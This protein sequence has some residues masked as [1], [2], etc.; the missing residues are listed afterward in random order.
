V[1]VMGIS[2]I[3]RDGVT[4]NR[5]SDHVEARPHDYTQNLPRVN[6]GMEGKENGRQ[7]CLPWMSDYLFS[8]I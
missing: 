8:S 2:P 4:E 3:A 6:E 7:E 5:V 1:S